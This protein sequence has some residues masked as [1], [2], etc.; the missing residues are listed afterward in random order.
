MEV[1]I[2]EVVFSKVAHENLEELYVYGMETFSYSSATDF[3]D[4][5]YAEI[6]KL[7]SSHLHH[8]ECRYLKTTSKKYRNLRFKNHLVIYRVSKTRIEVLTIIHS[9]RSVSKIKTARQI[10]IP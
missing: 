7:S 6:L 8:P 2:R 5:L 10:K 1:E 3:L 9:S 4:E